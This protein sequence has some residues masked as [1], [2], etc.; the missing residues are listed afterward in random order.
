M[1]MFDG[2]FDLEF[3]TESTDA[4]SLHTGSGNYP[5]KEGFAHVV[6]EGVSMTEPSDQECLSFKLDM[7]VYR[8]TDM[9]GVLQEDQVGRTCSKN[10][11]VEEWVNR[12]S[13]QFKDRTDFAK[14]KIGK[15]QATR[16]KA[17]FHAVGLLTDEQLQETSFKPNFAA[18]ETK[19]C[20]VKIQQKKNSKYIG[21]LWDTDFYR[22]GSEQV[23]DVYLDSEIAAK[24]GIDIP[25]VDTADAI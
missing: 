11:Y 20:I 6:I 13:D 4:D 7:R 19:Q 15:E 24:A 16:L 23:K 5:T 1:S 12:D 2:G 9:E 25:G 22:I 10:L 8:F 17:V 3:E 21:V 14:Q 18:L